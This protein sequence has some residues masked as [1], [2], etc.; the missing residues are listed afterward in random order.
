MRARDKIDERELADAGPHEQ[1]EIMIRGVLIIAEEM[2]GDERTHGH[3]E[4]REG[5][6]EREAHALAARLARQ[7]E[8]RSFLFVAVSDESGLLGELGHS[9]VPVYERIGELALDE[10]GEDVLTLLGHD[11]GRR[12]VLEVLRG[13]GLV[14]R[15]DGAH[16][17]QRRMGVQREDAVFF[18]SEFLPSRGGG[19]KVDSLPSTLTQFPAGHAD[20]PLVLAALEFDEF[21]RGGLGDV[22]ARLLGLAIA[23]LE[24]AAGGAM[25]A[26]LIVALTD[27]APVENRDSAV[28]SLPELDA[29]EPLVVRLQDVGLMLH[30]QRATL[31]LY[32]LN[33]HASSMQI[34][35]HE[36]VAILRRPVVALVDHHADMRVPATE[37]VRA[38]AT[39]VSIVPLL[40][41]VP[42]IVVRLLINEFVDE[43]IRIL[44]VHALKVR[45]VDALPAMTDDGVDEQQLVVLS[46]IGT[47]RVGGAVAVRLKDLGD[48][49]ITPEAAGG[50][51]ALF[52]GHARHVDPRGARDADAAVEPTIGTPLESVGEGVTARRSGAETVEH[53]L[54]RTGG[55]VAVHRNEEKVG[56]AH[57]IHA[58]EATLDAGEH[59]HL[60]GEDGALVEFAVVVAVLED[61][62]AVT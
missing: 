40:A 28:W 52:L 10:A 15:L 43:R 31:P 13:E 33:V 36:L 46:P 16:R 62:D 26:V 29:A 55:L 35:R 34:E 50:G 19:R 30:D 3:G 25:D 45:T 24:D 38:A 12:V 57:C 18:G 11:G 42:V 54:G 44:A 6:S 22:D 53:D 5:F 39:A 51:L 20:E 56:R 32:A 8:E 58:A 14:A 59:L 1:R 49:V 7:F 23:D 17:L 21:R 61:D 41:G 2:L 47:P 48:R 4:M 9:V 60:V 27:I 37:A